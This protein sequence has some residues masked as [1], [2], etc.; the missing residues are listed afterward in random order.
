MPSRLAMRL[1]TAGGRDDQRRHGNVPIGVT[2]PGT[3]KV[4]IQWLGR[5]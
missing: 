5:Q 4:R 3:P 1:L 2:W